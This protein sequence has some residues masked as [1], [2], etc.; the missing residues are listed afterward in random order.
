[1]RARPLLYRAGNW[2]P[3]AFFIFRDLCPEAS[4]FRPFWAANPASSVTF[5]LPRPTDPVELSGQQTVPLSYPDCQ[6][7]WSA[8]V[9]GPVA[10]IK[11]GAGCRKGRI[12]RIVVSILL[13]GHPKWVSTSAQER[14]LALV[15]VNGGHWVGSVMAGFGSAFEIAAVPLA[16]RQNVAPIFLSHIV[17]Y[18]DRE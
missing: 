14:T 4:D 9:V 5:R 18:L 17:I 13:L 1:M 12:W 16:T 10:T 11:D 15:V 7:A 8:A 2:T 6:R 3:N